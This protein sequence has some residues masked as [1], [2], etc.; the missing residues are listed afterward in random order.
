MNSEVKVETENPKQMQKIL[1]P[2]LEE[3]SPLDHEISTLEKSVTIKTQSD[4]VGQLRGG[5]D[6]AFRLLSLCKKILHKE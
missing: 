3:E 4:T 2:S 5:T 1:S 6:G